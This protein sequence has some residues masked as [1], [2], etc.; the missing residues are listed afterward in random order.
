[1]DESAWASP[2][3]LLTRDRSAEIKAAI[4]AGDPVL[5]AAYQELIQVAEWAL[6][7]TPDPVRGA[8]RAP[9]YYTRQRE[10]QRAVALPLR[11][12]GRSAH[13]LAL[14]YALS[15]E[16][17]YGEKARE[18]IFAWVEHMTHPG[19]G[20]P[21]YWL[22]ALQQRG[23]TPLVIAYSFPLYIYAF[24]LLR[25][26]GLLSDAEQARFRDWLR[27]YV[28]YHQREELYKN[29]HHNWQVVFLLAS[30]HVLQ[31]DALFRRAVG[32]YRNGLRVQI[33]GDGALPRELRRQQR[34]GTYTLMALEG[35]VQA[36]HIAAG[37]GINTLRDLPSRQAGTLRD[38]VRFYTEYLDD[39]GSW[40]AH[41]NADELNTPGTVADWG[42]FFE[43]PARWWGEEPFTSYLA[44]RPYGFD[45][46]RVYTTEFATLHFYAG[47]PSSSA[48]SA[49]QSGSP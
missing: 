42:W 1:V 8:M 20:N 36:V 26:G 40:R 35:M 7:Q 17:R 43:L 38:A 19:N 29:N 6:G 28:R 45:E 39:P 22:V 18:F 2:N 23:D 4:E 41:T 11:R 31:D 32:Y 30:A 24:D 25:G 47:R 14:A 44:Q 34:S 37:H 16:P 13:A 49:P 48:G 27:R 5:T 9:G 33:R 3:L 12:D 10:K 46:P 15:G 21:W